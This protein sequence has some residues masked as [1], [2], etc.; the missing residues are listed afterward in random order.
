MTRRREFLKLSSSAGIVGLAG[1]NISDAQNSDNDR[2]DEIGDNIEEPINASIIAFD[3]PTDTY[4]AGERASANVKV[5]H[6]GSESHTFY[7]GYGVVAPTGTIWDNDGTT[8]E[9]ITL[10]PGETKTVTVD[11]ITEPTAPPGSYEAGTAIW[12]REDD[13]N[14]YGQ[15]DAQRVEDAFTVDQPIE[16]VAMESTI[17]GIVTYM[18]GSPV[19]DAEVVAMT[20]GSESAMEL[21]DRTNETGEYTIHTAPGSYQLV[22]YKEIDGKEYA[23]SALTISIDSSDQINQNLT[24]QEWGSLRD[25][26]KEIAKKAK[27]V[28]E[29]FLDI[30][31]LIKHPPG[32]IIIAPFPDLWNDWLRN[33]AYDDEIQQTSVAHAVSRPVRRSSAAAPQPTTSQKKVTQ[34]SAEITGYSPANGSFMTG[35]VVPSEVTVENTGESAHTFFVGYGAVGPEEN[36][37]DNNGTTG[38]PVSLDPEETV[39]VTVK[40]TVPVES[41]EGVYD[42]GTAVWAESTPEHLQTKLDY[43]IDTDTITISG[44]DSEENITVDLVDKETGDSIPN[45]AVLLWPNRMGHGWGPKATDSNGT[46][47]FENLGEVHSFEDSS[48]LEVA[49]LRAHAA[50]YTSTTRRDLSWRPSD[51]PLNITLEMGAENRD[52]ERSILTVMVDDSDY[53]EI[54]SVT[55]EQNGDVVVTER[56]NSQ[57]RAQFSLEDGAEYTVSADGVSDTRT[58][59]VE[60][61]TEITLSRGS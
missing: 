19:Q 24:L 1:C 38:T 20:T 7:V 8:H 43:D 30:L 15:L 32:P 13:G 47:L 33:P 56:V 52:I 21:I 41:P 39:T 60:G 29:I 31:K 17:R 59:T 27:L 23:S 57:G 44:T 14:L 25:E 58:I 51:G 9:S 26:A 5:Q 42:L 45:G 18:D 6:T 35:D 40:W 11:W 28:I 54:P 22:A 53:P 55:V 3:P 2:G 61:D 37:Y 16:A 34:I 50:G 49:G 46:V 48:E 12:E 36:Q 10:D 4:Q